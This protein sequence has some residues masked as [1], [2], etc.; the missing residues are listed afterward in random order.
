MLS[1]QRSTAGN[2]SYP[3]GGVSC[4]KDNFVVSGAL[5]FQIKFCGKSPALRVAANRCNTFMKNLLSI[6]TLL[7]SISCIGQIH[8]TG[9]IVNQEGLPFKRGIIYQYNFD[10][11]FGETYPN[12]NGEFEI[13][14]KEPC[15]EFSF[16]IYFDG[17]YEM[18]IWKIKAT[19]DIY[20]GTIPMYEKTYVDSLLTLKRE[21]E[22]FNLYPPKI[23]L[24]EVKFKQ[25]IIGDM[26]KKVDDTY[27]L[28][29]LWIS[30]QE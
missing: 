4:S 17:F 9:K 11:F 3:K 19:N 10:C 16:R 18:R 15:E 5:V 12:K 30:M 27:I 7:T 1:R 6:I 22:H 13:Q 25:K 20:L 23:I 28:D 14:L 2:S 26:F 8:I 24:E 29:Y 21:N